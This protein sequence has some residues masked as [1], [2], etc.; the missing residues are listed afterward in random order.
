MRI[1]AQKYIVEEIIKYL[2]RIFTY[3]SQWVN[4][5][6]EAIEIHE[7]KGE[8]F[9]EEYPEIAE[10]YPFVTITPIGG[11]FISTGFNDIVRQ[12]D[13]DIIELGTR[14]LTYSRI[15]STQSVVSKLPVLEGEILRGLEIISAWTGEKV[16]GDDINY[17]LYKNYSTVPVVV[18]T[19]SF[20]GHTSVELVNTYAEFPAA[21]TCLNVPYHV[22]LYST[23]DSPYYISIDNTADNTYYY[24]EGSSSVSSSGSIV[25]SIRQ[26]AF[27]RIGGDYKGGF[28]LKIQ[29]KNDSKIVYALSELIS[30][31]LTLGRHGVVSRTGAV[32]GLKYGELS[33]LVSEFIQKGIGI[34]NI[35]LGALE[36]RKRSDQEVIYSITVSADV[37]TEWFEDYPAD[38]ITDI[39]V[40]VKTFIAKEFTN[41]MEP[42]T[43]N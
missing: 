18:A 10:R 15:S 21:I 22:K 43:L 34:S 25:G 12:V 42:E 37:L 35:R 36:K 41:V 13:D 2:R 26:P 19:G 1:T 6:I 24:V 28:T 14:G 3:N 4:S 40:L 33:D 8:L 17:I 38:S 31:Y 11:N 27:F 20:L 23:L 29:S 16:G 30:M 32:N 9:Y 5:D 7:G 39:D